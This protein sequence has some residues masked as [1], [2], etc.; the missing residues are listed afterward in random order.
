MSAFKFPDLS[1]QSSS[2]EEVV[3][4]HIGDSYSLDSI[5]L[6]IRNGEVIQLLDVLMQVQIY[7]DI[8]NPTISGFVEISDYV[9]GLEKFQLTGGELISIRIL[10]PNST[11]VVL[12]RNDLVVHTIS[13]GQFE[14]NNTIKYRLEFTTISAIRSQKN[15]IYKSYRNTRNISDVVKDMCG[16]INSPINIKDDLPISLNK[17]FIS[18][19]YTPIQAINYLAK[20]ACASGDYFLFFERAST[21]RVFAGINNLRSLAP[22]VEEMYTISYNPSLSYLED[23]G[24][25]SNMR[26]EV[27]E[28]EKNFNHMINMNKGMYY[29]KLT[30]VNIARRTY[31]TLDF[32]YRDG[33]NDFYVNDLLNEQCEFGNLT[34]DQKPGERMYIPAINDPM[35]AKTSW[36]K[37]DL[38]GALSMSGMRTKVMVAGSVNQLGAGDIV[39]LKLPSDEEKSFDAGASEVSENNMY[40]GKYFVTA[41]RHVIT[42]KTYV[43]QLELSRGSVRQ[44]LVGNVPPIESDVA[45]DQ[46][47]P[48]EAYATNV[49]KYINYDPTETP[50]EAE[51]TPEQRVVEIE[52]KEAEVAEQV[53]AEEEFTPIEP[54]ADRTGLQLG[55]GPYSFYLDSRIDMS[56]INKYI[57]GQVY[58]EPQLYNYSPEQVVSTAPLTDETR[59]EQANT[60]D[61][62]TTQIVTTGSTSTVI[63]TGG[64]NVDL[65]NIEINI[66]GID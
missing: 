27:V 24:G 35:Y 25:E 22:D 11:T 37:N 15:R 55:R 1:L 10:K 53:E 52:Q 40:S 46:I 63:N 2:R 20:R 26:T 41:C 59:Q 23:E 44:T 48:E 50:E 19:G 61:P 33:L 17:T 16:T 43:K 8:F 29:S 28:L 60:T 30:N 42:T 64:I 7:E 9:G 21:G 62:E 12:D 13:P 65:S 4:A 56:L 36:I 49:S 57:N 34:V 32:D 58:G 39:Y 31:D 66:R 3:E 54:V 47:S 5:N 18:P 38:H 51:Q 6:I 14:A 45:T